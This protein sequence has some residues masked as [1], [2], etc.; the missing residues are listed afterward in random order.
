M[1][2]TAMDDLA[3]KMGMDSLEFFKKNLQSHRHAA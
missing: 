2:Q 1:T 3:A